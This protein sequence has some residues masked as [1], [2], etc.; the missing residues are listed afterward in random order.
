MLTVHGDTYQKFEVLYNAQHG[1]LYAYLLNRT[2]DP[3]RY[4]S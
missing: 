1:A 4:T 2:R 3:S